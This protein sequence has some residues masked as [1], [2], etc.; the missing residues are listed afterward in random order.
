MALSRAQQRE[1]MQQDRARRALRY[2]ADSALLTPAE[3]DRVDQLQHGDGYYV[4]PCLVR[5][6]GVATPPGQI[7]VTRP[8]AGARAG[9]GT[10]ADVTV[11]DAHKPPE[12]LRQLSTVGTA[13]ADDGTPILTQQGHATVRV[14]HSDG[15]VTIEPAS[16]YTRARRTAARGRRQQSTAPQA[17]HRIM[18]SDPRFGNHTELASGDA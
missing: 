15:S 9:R 16:R 5:G 10:W 13:I 14:T 17:P 7:R 1:I 18:T 11:R 2:I 3:L 6:I 12:T 4:N 8:Y